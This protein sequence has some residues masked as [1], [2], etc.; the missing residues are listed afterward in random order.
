MLSSL[1]QVFENLAD[2][3]SHIYQSEAWCC[4]HDVVRR[5]CRIMLHRTHAA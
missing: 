2:L 5:E 3:L 4:V 1:A